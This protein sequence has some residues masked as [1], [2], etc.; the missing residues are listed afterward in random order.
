MLHLVCSSDKYETKLEPGKELIL[1]RGS[2]N[3]P[4]GYVVE[5][6]KH[7]TLLWADAKSTHVTLKVKS[8]NPI[9]VLRQFE[10]ES[11]TCTEA[12]LSFQDR[13]DIICDKKITKRY[14][15]RFTSSTSAASPV[16]TPTKR[17]R[18]VES[19]PEALSA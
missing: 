6:R 8:R 2:G 14:E 12:T 11:T 19:T 15:F 4:K 17:R 5:S 13:F 3:I 16:V 18:C 9:E 7:L 1:G 10:H